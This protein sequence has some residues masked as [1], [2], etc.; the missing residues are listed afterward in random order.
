MI[1]KNPMTKNKTKEFSPLALAFIGDGVHTLFV[2]DYVM[3]KQNLSAGS[4]HILASKICKAQT[5]S[6]IFDTFFNSFTEEEKD[7]ALRA[8]NHKSHSAKNA[9]PEDYK[10]ATALKPF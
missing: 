5:Q 9:N 7:I 1:E 4:F 10:K 3:K 8:R 2:R 6:K